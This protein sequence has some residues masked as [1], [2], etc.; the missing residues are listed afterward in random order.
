MNLLYICLHLF[1]R[2]IALIISNGSLSFH[3]MFTVFVCDFLFKNLN[4]DCFMGEK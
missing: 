1:N 4:S 2:G 3:N